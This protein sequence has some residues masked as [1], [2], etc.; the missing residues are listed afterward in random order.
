[1]K[2][3]GF[4]K[5]H[6]KVLSLS[7]FLFKTNDR[8]SC[9]LRKEEHQLL[10]QYLI[11]SDMIFSKTLAIFDGINYIAP[12]MIFSDGEWIWPSYYS[13]NLIKEDFINSDF[14]SHVKQKSFIITPL[15]GEQKK[16][17]TIFL[18]KEMLSF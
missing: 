5:V 17:L 6:D 1:M 12:Y 13:Y 2:I 9:F 7:K 14:L 8:A 11:K 18:E 15:T 16:E 4:S 10:I 3:I